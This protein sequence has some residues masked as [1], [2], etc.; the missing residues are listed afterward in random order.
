[1]ANTFQG[2]FPVHDTGE[3]GHAGITSVAQ[4]PPNGYG[5]YD[6]AGNVWQWTSDWYRADYYQQLAAAG[7]VTRNPRGPSSSLDPS[8]P[9][10]KKR[11]M[12]GGSFLCT[13]Q[14]CSRYLVGTRGKGEEST[15]TN[16]LGFRCVRDPK[17]TDE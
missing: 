14:Y 17:K 8:E 5:L 11:V 3:D 1:M 2:R 15:G 4:Y 12:R 13:D 10:E 6:M 9:G 16:H 7:G